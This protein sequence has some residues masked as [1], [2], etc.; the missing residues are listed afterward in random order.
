VLH[1]R[2]EDPVERRA[3]LALH[4][5]SIE[6]PADRAKFYPIL[7]LLRDARR[8]PTRLQLG[9][10]AHVVDGPIALGDLEPERAAVLPVRD[11][12]DEIE[13]K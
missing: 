5:E 8:A 2:R 9:H 4:R 12:L 13:K 3:E 1:E 10:P 6:E 11:A 7:E